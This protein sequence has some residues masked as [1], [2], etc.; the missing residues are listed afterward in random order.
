MNEY[1]KIK[2]LENHVCNSLNSLTYMYMSKATPLRVP[3]NKCVIMT[4]FDTTFTVWD[5]KQYICWFGDLLLSKSESS[6]QEAWHRL[7]LRASH[8]LRKYSP[9]ES[10]SFVSV[11]N[12]FT[13]NFEWMKIT[14]EQLPII[15]ERRAWVNLLFV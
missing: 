1:T 14:T 15:K 6:I 13:A 2:Y 3:M 8:R 9:A 7:A 5:L 11:K 12:V 10:P 4:S